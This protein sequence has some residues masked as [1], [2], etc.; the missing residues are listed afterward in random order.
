MKSF[1]IKYSRGLQ[2]LGGGGAAKTTGLSVVTS[3]V[4][5]KVTLIPTKYGEKIGHIQIDVPYENIDKVVKILQK[6]KKSLDND[7]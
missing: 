3:V 4:P 5:M 2:S 7:D 1:S 6:A